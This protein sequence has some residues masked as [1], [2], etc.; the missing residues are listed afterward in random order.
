MTAELVGLSYS[1]WTEK[2]RWALDHCGVGYRYTEHLLIL[3]MPSLRA[4]LGRWKGGVT[5]P[6]FI[7]GST[8]LTDSFLIAR[9]ADREGK[10]GL[11]PE[12]AVDRVREFNDLSESALDA[13]R[14]ALLFRMDA[15]RDSRRQS[16]P[17]FVP[18]A[19][20]PAFEP[21]ARLGMAYIRSEFALAGKTAE[22]SEET[23]RQVLKRLRAA[24]AEGRGDYVI[25]ERFSYADIV[26]AVV[27]QA[28]EPVAE[29]FLPLEPAVRRVWASPRL[30][31]EF[32]DLVSWRDRIYERHR[33]KYRGQ[34]SSR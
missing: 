16:L 7:D 13:A 9:H 11:F 17:G 8:R 12:G 5:V 22:G 23:I 14:V 21:V 33:L 28:V 18:R 3:G 32:G 15:D 29:R 4:K 31:E 30:R 19:L 26:L 24:L 6:A 20:R 34:P 2:A 25:G 1:P 10:A 27:L